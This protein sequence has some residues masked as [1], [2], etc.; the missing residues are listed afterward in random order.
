MIVNF[1]VEIPAGLQPG[2]SFKVAAPRE[3]KRGSGLKVT[4]PDGFH[5][6]DELTLEHKGKVF[7]INVPEGKHPGDQFICQAPNNPFFTRTSVRVT[8]PEK[9]GPGD[10]LTVELPDMNG[11]QFRV[12]VPDGAHSGD[13]FMTGIP[14]A[15]EACAQMA[16]DAAEKKAKKKDKQAQHD[17]R[18]AAHDAKKA[19]HEQRR[20][21]RQA[22]RDELAK[23]A[24]PGQVVKKKGENGDGPS[25]TL[26]TTSE[27]FPLT[28]A[29]GLLEL[30]TSADTQTHANGE[31]SVSKKSTLSYDGDPLIEVDT[32]E[33]FSPAGHMVGGSGHTARL[34]EDSRELIVVKRKMKN[35]VET[36]KEKI[37]SIADLILA[38]RATSGHR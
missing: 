37:H 38:A 8:V 13:T 16:E 14:T 7:N 29:P 32:T 35:G 19:E 3:N 36:D 24:V 15:E 34:S 1:D 11:F 22:R 23:G 17:S 21:G 6:G 2:D 10:K 12:T 9:K 31:K 4:V 20:S 28:V 27:G 18:V 33:D 30:H 26:W 25:T 5:P